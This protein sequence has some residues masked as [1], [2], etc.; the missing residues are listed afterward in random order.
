MPRHIVLGSI[1]HELVYGIAHF[2]LKTVHEE[3]HCTP[4]NHLLWLAYAKDVC[5]LS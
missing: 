5:K 1:I 2:A 3:A 4:K